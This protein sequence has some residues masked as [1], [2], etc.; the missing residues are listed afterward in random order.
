MSWRAAS[1]FGLDLNLVL[2]D[3]A[4]HD[5]DLGDAGDQEPRA[6]QPL[7]AVAEIKEVSAYSR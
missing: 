2:A 5:G 7:D 1:A 6:D 3:L 4:S